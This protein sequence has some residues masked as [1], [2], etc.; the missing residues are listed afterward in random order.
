MDLAISLAQTHYL[1]PSMDGARTS[2]VVS[3]SR[4]SHRLDTGIG[5]VREPPRSSELQCNMRGVRKQREP[6]QH[7]CV[8]ARSGPDETFHLFPSRFP[9]VRRAEACWICLAL[10]IDRP[11]AASECRIAYSLSHLPFPL[12]VAPNNMREQAKPNHA[13]PASG[14]MAL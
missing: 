8:G 2:S 10:T 9:N 3:I 1:S 14:S 12:P 4:F 13:K 11:T 7:S 6:Q 5:S